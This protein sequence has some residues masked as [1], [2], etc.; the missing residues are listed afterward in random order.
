MSTLLSA[1]KG[2]TI[3]DNKIL[4]KSEIIRRVKVLYPSTET[5]RGSK[6]SEIV[7]FLMLSVVE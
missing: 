6:F 1:F 2:H 3:Y 7:S 4:E 5:M